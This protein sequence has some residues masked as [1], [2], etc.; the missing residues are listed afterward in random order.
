MAAMRLLA[1]PRKRRKTPARRKRVSSLTTVSKRVRRYRRNPIRMGGA[2]ESVKNGAVGAV[3]ALAVDFA[4]Q[5]IPLPL[6]MTTGPMLPA[7]K[8]AVGI[9]IGMLV[10][11]L[12]KNKKLGT[13]LADGAVTVSLYEF[14]KQAIGPSIGLSDY[15]DFYYMGE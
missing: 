11:K 6:A 1:N 7:A 13:Q 4:L 15:S 9:G 3:G 8:A 10:S 14:G 12:G 2:M 5:K